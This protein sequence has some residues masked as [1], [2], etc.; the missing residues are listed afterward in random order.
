MNYRIVYPNEHGTLNLIS[1]TGLYSVE[2]TAKKDVPEGVPY[3]IVDVN[4]L[5]ANFD[6]FQAWECDFSNPDG[7]GLG[8]HAWMQQHKEQV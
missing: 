7:Y 5:P 1:P 2:Q 4:N 8:Y 6:F 3:R